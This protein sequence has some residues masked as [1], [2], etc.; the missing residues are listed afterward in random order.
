M[1]RGG[2]L[3]FY[4]VK[5]WSQVAKLDVVCVGVIFIVITWGI[6]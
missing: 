5:K 4:F 6:Y 1:I 3:Y 2:F